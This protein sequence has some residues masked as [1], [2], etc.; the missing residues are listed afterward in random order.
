MLHEKHLKDH[1]QIDEDTRNVRDIHTHK[2]FA[3]QIM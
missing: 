1:E 3:I 2:I